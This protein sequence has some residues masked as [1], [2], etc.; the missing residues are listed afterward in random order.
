MPSRTSIWSP[1]SVLLLL[2]AWLRAAEAK[3][4]VICVGPHETHTGITTFLSRYAADDGSGASSFDGWSWPIIE[5]K[6][7]DAS[8]QH[9][10]DLLVKEQDDDDIQDIL[11]DGIRSAWTASKHGVFI[12]SLDFDKVG[13]N[14]YSGYD[15]VE[16]LIRVIDEVGISAEDVTV[17]VTYRTSRVNQWGVVWGNHFDAESYE[18]FVCSNEQ[19]Y[20]RW[21]WLDTSMNPFKVAKTYHDQEWNVVVVDEDSIIKAG[22]D[23]PNVVACLVMEN[24]NCEDGRVDGLEEIVPK[25]GLAD[26][27]DELGAEDRSDLE[28][29]FLFRDCY[30]VTQLD[31]FRF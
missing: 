15:A 1:F 19:S 25:T 8:P 13:A 21:E 31:E 23:V 11:I 24:E 30:Y 7:I 10:F 16:S 28:R 2:T 5:S 6:D 9:V 22:K 29:L 20:K 12:G 17:I 14:P 4:F 27:I 3:K 26:E 18:D